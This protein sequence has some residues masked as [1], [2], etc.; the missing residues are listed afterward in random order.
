MATSGFVIAM[1]DGEI[2]QVTDP[3]KNVNLSPFQQWKIPYECL[4][5]TSESC[6]TN[7]TLTEAGWKNVTMADKADFCKSRGCGEHTKAVLTC[8]HLV[9]RDYRFTNNATDLHSSG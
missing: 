2:R 6:S 3:T 4:Q 9:K 8:I 1:T 7:Y 5:N